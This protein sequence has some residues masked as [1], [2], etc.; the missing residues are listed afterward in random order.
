VKTY[1]NYDHSWVPVAQAC[2]PSY[3]GGRDQEDHGSNPAWA[4]SSLEPISKK[5][6]THT[7]KKPNKPKKQN[8]DQ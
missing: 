2:N 4:N 8:Y 5:P 6:I 3:P 7:H 1:K